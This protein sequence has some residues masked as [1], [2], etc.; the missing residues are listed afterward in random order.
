VHEKV[1]APMNEW[2]NGEIVEFIEG[3]AVFMDRRPYGLRSGA[4][5]HE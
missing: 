5:G 2:L 4:L 3:E 1:E